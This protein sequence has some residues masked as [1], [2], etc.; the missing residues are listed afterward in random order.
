[1]AKNKAVLKAA[2]DNGNKMIIDTKKLM[3]NTTGK[4][5]A[6]EGQV[7]SGCGVHQSKKHYTRKSKHKELMY[8]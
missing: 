8:N 4:L 6:H 2:G 1:M 3:M 7:K 5:G